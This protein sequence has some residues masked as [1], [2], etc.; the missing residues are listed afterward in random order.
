MQNSS[1]YQRDDKIDFDDKVDKDDEEEFSFQRE[2]KET[3]CPFQHREIQPSSPFSS[4]F[5]SQLQSYFLNN[6]F[7][8][9][10]ASSPNF[11]P[12]NPTRLILSHHPT[13]P[14]FISVPLHSEIAASPSITLLS[15]HSLPLNAALVESKNFHIHS[16]LFSNPL[17]KSPHLQQLHS[18]SFSVST[19]KS[20]SRSRILSKN[21]VR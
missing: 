21:R 2:Q 3:G 16:T 10:M 8:P 11:S 9:S 14:S 7:P 5:I 19:N 17:A 13:L 4:T 12:T 18:P 15:S 20:G 1:R 6:A